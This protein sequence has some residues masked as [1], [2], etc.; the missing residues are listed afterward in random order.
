MHPTR[1]CHTHATR[2]IHTVTESRLI[3]YGQQYSGGLIDDTHQ[4]VF[5]YISNVMPH[6]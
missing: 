2:H 1:C 6:R 4:A 3:L 5:D